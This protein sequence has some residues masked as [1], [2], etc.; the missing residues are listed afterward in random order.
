[1]LAARQP[2][3]VEPVCVCCLADS[4]DCLLIA[5]DYRYEPPYHEANLTPRSL[6]HS[7]FLMRNMAAASMERYVVYGSPKHSS[8]TSE[9]ERD[10]TADVNSDA[11]VTVPAQTYSR[12]SLV[13]GPSITGFLNANFRNLSS[14]GSENVEISVL[15]RILAPPA[16]NSKPNA[17]V[18]R[19]DIFNMW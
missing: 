9:T 3:L 6:N 5:E 18:G 2:W 15:P 10:R 17:D 14:K 7:T 16:T 4:I 19:L 13:T 12:E 8:I 1:M 11:T